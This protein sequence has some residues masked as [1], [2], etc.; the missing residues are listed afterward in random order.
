LQQRLLDS[1]GLRGF[2]LHPDLRGDL[3][4]IMIAFF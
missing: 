3:I 2:L 1:I 4:V